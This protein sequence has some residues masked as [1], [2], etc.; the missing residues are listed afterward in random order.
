MKHMGRRKVRERRE[1]KMAEAWMFLRR[2]VLLA[3]MGGGRGNAS[4]R[5]VSVPG[6]IPSEQLV[7]HP[8]K[9]VY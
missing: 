7:E 1:S 9:N 4:R 6:A 5:D 8:D 3:A 2:M